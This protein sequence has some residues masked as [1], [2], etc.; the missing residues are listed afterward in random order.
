MAKTFTRHATS[1]QTPQVARAV[2]FGCRRVIL[3]L[4]PRSYRIRYSS[5]PCVTPERLG[6]LHP[7]FT[8]DRFFL[9][10]QRFKHHTMFVGVQNAVEFLPTGIHRP[11]HRGLRQAPRAHRLAKLKRD[12]ALDGRGR[13]L[14]AYL[15]EHALK[16]QN[17]FLHRTFLVQPRND[18]L[19]IRSLSICV[20]FVRATTNNARRL[21]PLTEI[22]S[23]SPRPDPGRNIVPTLAADPARAL[24][25]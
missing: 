24:T 11:R 18:R 12:Y 7:Q 20:P 25:S 5:C 21:A 10:R 16:R 15:G 22:A 14:F 19:P 17:A 4:P 1:A 8:A 3:C 13:D 9:P 2:R 23:R 6:H